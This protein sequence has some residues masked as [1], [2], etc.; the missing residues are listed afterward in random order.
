MP[1]SRGPRCR[2]QVTPVGQSSFGRRSMK[3]QSIEEGSHLFKGNLA[4]EPGCRGR[5]IFQRIACLALFAGISIVPALAQ[6]TSA[7]VVGTATDASGAVLSG[8]TVVLTDVNTHDQRTATS[9][10]AGEFTFT[11]LKPGTYSLTVTA[12]GFK[13]FKVD[14]FN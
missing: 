12:P 2:T 11:L 8:A 7:D 4:P 1:G 13:T 5:K 14:S 10:G 3:Y 9:G 6:N